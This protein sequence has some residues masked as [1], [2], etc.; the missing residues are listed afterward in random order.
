M[1]HSKRY[2]AAAMAALLL[3]ASG[4]G[5]A[6][7]ESSKEDNSKE[8]IVSSTSDVFSSES[9]SEESEA[10]SSDAVSEM[11]TDGDAEEKE[12]INYSE[13]LDENGYWEGVTALDFV[14][15]LKYKGLKVPAE[16]HVVED[17]QVQGEIDT[18]TASFAEKKEV[19][20]GVIEDGSTVNIDY[21]GSIDGVEFEGGNTDGAGTEVTI[22]VTSFI[23]D[24]LE[25]LIGH[26][27]GESFDI[28]VTFPEDY[29]KE[30][31]NGKDAVFAITVNY[32][33][34]TVPIEVNDEFVK[35]N[36][37]PQYEWETV[38]GMKT[39]IH[40]ALQEQL[41]RDFM[42]KEIVEI[43]T[44]DTPPEVITKYQEKSLI[45]AYEDYAAN[46]GMTLEDFLKNQMELNNAQELVESKADEVEESAKYFLVMQAIAED[47][48]IIPTNADVEEFFGESYESNKEQYGAPY[49][50][51]YY[52]HEKIVELLI[53]EAVLES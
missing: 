44:I 35:E 32:I 26:S 19:T 13:G 3:F 16:N 33:V 31:L 23:D 53:N 6:G 27:P 28:E 47:A 37:S 9:S 8:E 30:E 34:E 49:L 18:I 7:T 14:K 51:Q 10:D 11:P 29:G 21:V 45:N 38:D 48:G 25:Q 46:F 20:D 4:C 52:I 39:G 22:G 43:N 24:F 50:S 42:L 17:A 40:K 1:K 15:D 41:L 5:S 36:L 12:E 2:L